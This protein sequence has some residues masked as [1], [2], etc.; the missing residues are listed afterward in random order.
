MLR[1]LVVSRAIRD[2]LVFW[3]KQEIRF[4]KMGSLFSSAVSATTVLI[5]SVCGEQKLQIVNFRS[6]GN[7]SPPKDQDGS[8]LQINTE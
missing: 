2:G 6:L 4:L 7:D 5:Q 1:V 3:K 8:R